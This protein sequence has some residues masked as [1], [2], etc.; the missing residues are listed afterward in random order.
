VAY[1]CLIV[2]CCGFPV[3]WAFGIQATI[4]FPR[5]AVVIHVAD[6]FKPSC[7]PEFNHLGNCVTVVELFS[8][9]CV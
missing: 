4:S 6:F 8:N 1:P 3:G 9:F 5:C 2:L 7:S